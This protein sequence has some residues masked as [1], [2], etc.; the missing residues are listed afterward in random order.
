ML[1]Q[2]TRYIPPQHIFAAGFVGLFVLVILALI[3]STQQLE[4]RT[5]LTLEI[6]PKE[7][8]VI[9]APPPRKPKW[10]EETIGKGDNLAKVFKR[11]GLSATDLH[12]LGQTKHKKSL[13]QI[14]PGDRLAYQQDTQ[15]T[16]QQAKLIISPLESYHFRRS[17]EGFTSEHVM[18]EPNVQYAYGSATIENSLFLAGQEANLSQN[19]IMEMADI[20]AYDVDFSLDIRSGDQFELLYE[21]LF[22]DGQKIKNGNIVA[23]RFVNRDRDLTAVRYED[24]TGSSS[25]FN[26]KGLS[27]RKAFMRNPVDF[28]RIS[29]RFNLKRKHPILHKIRAHKGVDYAAKRGTPIKAVGKG[30]VIWAGT[31]GGY[32]RTVILQHGQR[33]TTLYAHMNK[34][35]KGI[36]SGRYVEQGQIIGY[37]GSSGLASGPHL[38]YEFRVNG[39]HKN[40]L[41]VR[42]PNAKPIPAKE[43]KKFQGQAKQV[44]AKLETF[45]QAYEL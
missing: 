38:H 35:G 20:F 27:M 14:H 4:E 19:I 12:Y 33:Y 30:K 21:E 8:E 16:L 31:K 6:K 22:L 42:F 18:R 39:T 7:A 28:A 17:D 5:S 3:P 34:Y 29:S 45:R 2:L 37:V 10:P 15:G 9:I 23:A 11:A 1:R 25:Y 40:P 43:R 36:R 24:N 32:G 41:T 13:T 26:P 44:L